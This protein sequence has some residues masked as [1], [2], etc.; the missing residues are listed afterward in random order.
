LV[1]ELK[2]PSLATEACCLLFSFFAASSDQEYVTRRD[3]VRVVNVFGSNVSGWFANPAVLSFFSLE[4]VCVS[5]PFPFLFPMSLIHSS[6]TGFLL[7]FVISR[8]SGAPMVRPWFVGAMDRAAAEALLGENRGAFLVRFVGSSLCLSTVVDDTT[9]KP[10][11]REDQEQQ[12]ALLPTSK[13]VHWRIELTG[14][15]FRLA[16]YTGIPFPSLILLIKSLSSVCKVRP[17]FFFF[18]LSAA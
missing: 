15:G 18:A 2:S 11:S 17:D 5:I 13:C 6:V 16:S 4:Y 1:G 3:F 14:N 9:A 7:R 10:P 12:L 8:E